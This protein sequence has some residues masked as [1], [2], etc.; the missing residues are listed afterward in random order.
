MGTRVADFVSSS[1]GEVV[2]ITRSGFLVGVTFFVFWMAACGPQGP[3]SGGADAIA[4]QGVLQ[5]DEMGNLIVAST[6]AEA[7][8]AVVK[9]EKSPKPVAMV[10]K[11]ERNDLDAEVNEGNR[12]FA[13]V[14][15]L[16]DQVKA[17][18]GIRVY[19]DNAKAQAKKFSWKKLGSREV[20]RERAVL[21]EILKSIGRIQE[22][23]THKE[24]HYTKWQMKSGLSLVKSNAQAYADSL[25]LY[26]KTKKVAL[27]D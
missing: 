3:R 19:A 24:V 11:P 25:E 27:K 22:I 26:L 9:T 15:K 8:S 10:P 4:T 5:I 13:K 2:M 17:R 18:A 14:K 1:V 6:E 7:E 20:H 21:S 16:I 12:R 23:A